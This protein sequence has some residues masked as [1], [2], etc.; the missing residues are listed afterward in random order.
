MDAN[1]E[2]VQPIKTDR[3]NTVLLNGIDV[4][5]FVRIRGDGKIQSITGTKHFTGDL[6]ATAA[7]AITI[8][9]V[10]LNVLNETIL[11]KSGE[12]MLQGNITFKKITVNQ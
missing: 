2:F 9:N 5:T 8:N 12:Q 7:D 11:K 1:I 3:L 6:H 4:N 10:Q